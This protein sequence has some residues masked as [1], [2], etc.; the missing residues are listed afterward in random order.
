QMTFAQ[1]PP[2]KNEVLCCLEGSSA[3]S[4]LPQFKLKWYLFIMV[5]KA[6]ESCILIHDFVSSTLYRWLLRMMLTTL[7]KS[8]ALYVETMTVHTGGETWI[9]L[10]VAT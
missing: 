8:C 9:E 3:G 5:N 10:P 4:E 7:L 6:E 2:M 1:K